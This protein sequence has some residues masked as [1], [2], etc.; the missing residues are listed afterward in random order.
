MNVIKLTTKI[1]RMP[2]NCNMLYFSEIIVDFFFD[3]L[4]KDVKSLFL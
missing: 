4:K 1:Q 2:P 3:F